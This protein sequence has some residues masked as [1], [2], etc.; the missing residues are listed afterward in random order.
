VNLTSEQIMAV[1]EGEP[2]SLV[3]PEV[4]EACVLL[5]RDVY[6]QAANSAKA[7]LPSPL[8]VARLVAA[9]AG[10]EDLDSYQQYKR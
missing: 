2:V 10:E 6:E 5:R 8:G 3:L 4:G 9:V 7:D 1:R